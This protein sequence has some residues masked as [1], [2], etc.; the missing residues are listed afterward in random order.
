MVGAIFNYGCNTIRLLNMSRNACMYEKSHCIPSLTSTSA[1]Q[2]KKQDLL[3]KI[4]IGENNLTDKECQVV[5]N[6]IWKYRDIISHGIEDI[7]CCNVME[8]DIK[9][10]PNSKPVRLPPYRTGYLQSKILKEQIE[11]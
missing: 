9:L 8:Y 4:N 11:R 2:M 6:L 3:K 5:G 1:T 10:K 7:G